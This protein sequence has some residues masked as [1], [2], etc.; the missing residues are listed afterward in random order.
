MIGL[1]IGMHWSVFSRNCFEDFLQ[2]PRLKGEIGRN[3]RDVS[4]SSCGQQPAQEVSVWRFTFIM[5]FPIQEEDMSTGYKLLRQLITTLI[6]SIP[7]AE[8]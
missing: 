2:L 1:C 6:L 5:C 8:M 3:W 7:F 4:H